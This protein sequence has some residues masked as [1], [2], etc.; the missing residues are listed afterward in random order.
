MLKI[1]VIIKQFDYNSLVKITLPII[2]P[3]IKEIPFDDFTKKAVDELLNVEDSKIQNA[4]SIVPDSLKTAL[5]L[6]AFSGNLKRIETAID[7]FLKSKQISLQVKD[8]SIDNKNSISDFYFN[9]SV[10]VI[11][12]C[13]L[14]CGILPMIH[15]N[16]NQGEMNR[17]LNAVFSAIITEK[18]SMQ[19]IIYAID[20]KLIDDFVVYIINQNSGKIVESIGS[21]AEKKGF[22][23]L[24]SDFRIGIE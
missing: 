15:L 16:P 23:L 22:S 6:K 13:S 5:I 3:K 1:N 12:Y 17:F 11:D 21:F 10:D 18:N 9:C 24:I 8:I 4:F 20:K 19:S 7:S 2:K 14:V